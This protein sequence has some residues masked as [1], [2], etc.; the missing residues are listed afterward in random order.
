MNHRR[1]ITVLAIIA[2]SGRARLEG[3]CG[4]GKLNVTGTRVSVQKWESSNG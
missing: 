3:E 4:S 1:D 2:T